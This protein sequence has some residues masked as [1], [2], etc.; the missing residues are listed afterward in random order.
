MEENNNELVLE[1]SVPETLEENEEQVQTDTSEGEEQVQEEPSKE[2]IERQIEERASKLMEERVE[3]RLVRD[4]AKRER[5]QNKEMAKYKQLENIIKAGLGVD[6]LDEAIS[7]SSEFYQANGVVIPEYKSLSDKDEEILAKAYAEEIVSTGDYGEMEYE[8]NRIANI[9]ADKRSAKENIM[10]NI[11]CQELVEN[12][13]RKILQAKGYDVKILENPEFKEFKTKLNY[14]IPVVEAIE[15]FKK[16]NTKD[17]HEKPY[18]VGSAKNVVKGK[19]IKEYY[20]PEDFDKLS[21]EDLKNPKI[22]EAVD[23]SRVN[24]YK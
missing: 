1:E 20:T 5:I 13:N 15:M 9:P 14:N 16:I 6:S 19:E 12:N 2:D 11:L 21:M 7:K 8:A 17:K 3:E 10:F 23:K 22:M 24:W 18:S 4:R